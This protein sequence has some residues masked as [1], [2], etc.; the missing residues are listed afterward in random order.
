MTIKRASAAHEDLLRL[1]EFL[2]PVNQQAAAREVR[3]LTEGPDLLR[4][5]LRYPY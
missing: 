5:Q 2:R 3:K 4:S 1:H